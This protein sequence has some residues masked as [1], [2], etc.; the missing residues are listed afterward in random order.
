MSICVSTTKHCLTGEQAD[1]RGRYGGESV[2]TAD[3]KAP[4]YSRIVNAAV[5][6]SFA[7]RTS[8]LIALLVIL[9]V[10]VVQAQNAQTRYRWVDSEGHR[11]LSDEV[12]ADAARF[13]YDV[14]NQYG[15]VIRHVDG[16]KTPEQLAA[17]K[18]QAEQRKLALAQKR[19]DE[20][21]LLTY[22]TEE[23]LLKAQSNQVDMTEQRIESTRINMKSQ[24]DSLAN[25][26]DQ[27][28]Q[29]QQ[30]GKPVPPYLQVNIDK[31]RK[32]IRDQRD[33]VARTEKKLEQTRTDN[34]DTLTRYRNMR[35]PRKPSLPASTS[36]ASTP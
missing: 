33:W 9:P 7:V 30:N 2:A 16:A 26:L 3:V 10:Q 1:S 29:L 11:H 5:Q 36:S 28:A 24:L 31:Q 20:N 8:L 23:E 21:L 13:G 12:P 34:A 15:R 35:A 6:R 25:L 27:A 17:E 14:L 18:Q 22:P 32:T 4:L 19:R